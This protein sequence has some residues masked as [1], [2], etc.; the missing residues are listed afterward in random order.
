LE[1]PSHWA[2]RWGSAPREP[3]DSG[4]LGRPEAGRKDMEEEN[5]QKDLEEERYGFDFL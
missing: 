2:G 3:E 1:V 4:G 5:G